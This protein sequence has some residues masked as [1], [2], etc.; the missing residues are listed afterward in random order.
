M[1]KALS[2]QTSEDLCA[3]QVITSLPDSIKELIDNSIDAKATYIKIVL[4]EYG[5]QRVE[6][7]DNGI[8]I[9]SFDFMGK[10]GTTS[11]NRGDEKFDY[12]GF[13]G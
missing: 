9:D 11:K 6:V 4:T 2:Q 13:R 3:Q 1:I 5:K 8:G 7:I 10:K 12:L